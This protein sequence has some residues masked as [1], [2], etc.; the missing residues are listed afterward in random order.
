MSPEEFERLKAEEKAHLQKLR[1]L[2]R[3]H[4]DVQRKVSSAEALNKMRN[5]DLEAE[6]GRLTDDLFLDAAR[7]EARLDLALEGHAPVTGNAD[8]LDRE[9][10]AKAEAEALVKQ[11]KAAMGAAGDPAVEPTPRPESAAPAG[12]KTIGRTPPPADEPPPVA[13]R[14][15]KTIG[16]PKR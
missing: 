12:Q 8:D 10:L 7:Q 2:K 9:A 1:D 3:T 16:R 11:M 5:P 14:D 4:G 6:T 13:D 15:A